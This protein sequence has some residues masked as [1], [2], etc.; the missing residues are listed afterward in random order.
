MPNK[1]LTGNFQNNLCLSWV[2]QAC[3]GHYHK[4]LPIGC[5]QNP[6]AGKEAKLNLLVKQEHQKQ[7][8]LII[9]AG[10]GGL[11]AAITADKKGHEV[12]L[13]DKSDSIGGLLKTLRKAPMRQEM[14]ETMID[15]YSLAAR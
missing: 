9:G 8:V 12:I 2:L 6:V 3:I 11:Q 5:V 4:G 13:A 7:R 10:P 14:A 1:A 15:N